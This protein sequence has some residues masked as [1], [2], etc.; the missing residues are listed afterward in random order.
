MDNTLKGKFSDKL[1]DKYFDVVYQPPANCWFLKLAV[2][3]PYDKP[4]VNT[5]ITFNLLISGQAIGFGAGE[6]LFSKTNDSV[7]RN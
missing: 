1:K 6:G 5:T 7:T 2:D 4:G 3:A